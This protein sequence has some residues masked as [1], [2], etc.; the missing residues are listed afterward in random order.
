MNDRLEAREDLQAF[1]LEVLLTIDPA[2]LA[3][4]HSVKAGKRMATADARAV[5][6]S[7][8]RLRSSASRLVSMPCS[9][10]RASTSLRLGWWRGLYSDAPRTMPARR[11]SCSR[12]RQRML[13]FIPSLYQRAVQA[14][15]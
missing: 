3:P 5:T 15:Y 2:Q 11:A 12:P 9:A 4:H 6:P 14:L 8:A 13:H 7:D 1:V 10:M